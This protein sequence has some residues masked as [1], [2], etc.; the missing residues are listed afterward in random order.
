MQP[1]NYTFTVKNGALV[2]NPND[3]GIELKQPINYNSI[4]ENYTE[5]QEIYADMMAPTKLKK[6]YDKEN[7]RQVVL[8]SIYKNLLYDDLARKQ[9]AIE[10]P[11]QCS[12][13]HTNIVQGYEYAD[14]DNEHL[15]VMEYVNCAEYLKEKIDDDLNQV[16][17]EVKL[18]SFMADLLEAISYVH[19]NGI[20]HSDIK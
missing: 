9:A 1:V 15:I 11:L 17:N 5:T 12:L 19:E 16:K 7:D 13:D 18:K 6:G 4:I 3:M 20:A 8:K 10:F 14:S 2:C